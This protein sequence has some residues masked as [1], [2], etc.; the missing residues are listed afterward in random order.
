MSGFSL[1]ARFP[2]ASASFLAANAGLA[3]PK[4]P[5]VAMVLAQKSPLAV[6]FEAM[7]TAANGPVYASEVTVCDG[8]QWRW[9]YFWPGHPPVALELQ[10]GIYLPLGK[11]QGGHG[12]AERMR[13][14]CDKSNEAARQGIR[15]FKLAT[16]QV[17]PERVSMIL[18]FIRHHQLGGLPP[19]A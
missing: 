13:N 11:G 9:D 15:L 17:T 12:T 4:P 7:W 16:G 18:D 10:G 5:T 14:D 19:S 6:Q 1:A 2:K 3:A 8:R